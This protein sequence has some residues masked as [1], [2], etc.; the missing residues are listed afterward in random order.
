M[1]HLLIS[2]SFDLHQAISREIFTIPERSGPISMRIFQGKQVFLQIVVLMVQQAINFVS[3]LT[4][5][6]RCRSKHFPKGAG[7]SP[8][9]HNIL[10]FSPVCDLNMII[11]DQEWYSS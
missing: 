5:L 9:G 7:S 11:R 10:D 6:V 1:S 8:G 3:N 4:Q 2:L